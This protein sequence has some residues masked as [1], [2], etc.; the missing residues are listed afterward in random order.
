MYLTHCI[1]IFTQT[2]F[3][4]DLLGHI[5]YLFLRCD[6]QRLPDR[7]PDDL[8]GQSLAQRIYRQ[9]PSFLF[10]SLPELR[11]DERQGIVLMVSFPYKYINQSRFKIFGQVRL[12]KPDQ[13]NTAARI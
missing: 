8:L 10:Q 13:L 9:Y 4:P 1:V 5:F 2:V 11:G 3:L 6:F 12:I 7:S